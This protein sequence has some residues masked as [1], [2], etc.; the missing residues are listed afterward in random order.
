LPKRILELSGSEREQVVT[1]GHLK[2]RAFAGTHGAGTVEVPPDWLEAAYAAGAGR[3]SGRDDAIGSGLRGGFFMAM[4]HLGVFPILV[5]AMAAPALAGTELRPRDLSP[6]TWMDAPAHPPVEIVREGR[7]R[8][9][10]YGADPRGHETYDRKKHGNY[11]P[12]LPVLI[13]ELVE[14]VRLSTGATLDQVHQAPPAD[15]P[16]IVIGDCEESR[17]NSP[18]WSATFGRPG[19]GRAG[20]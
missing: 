10:V 6:V 11:P 3:E 12:A 9:V 8:A 1:V 14:V 4:K 20:A 19:T 16:A 18:D 2:G 7:A 15:R 5:A 13:N 17:A